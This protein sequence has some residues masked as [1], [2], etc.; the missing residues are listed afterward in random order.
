MES[1]K[2]QMDNVKFE[3]ESGNVEMESDKLE[4]LS[5][6]VQVDRV[7]L[8]KES[9]KLEVDSVKL[10]VESDKFDMLC[11]TVQMGSVKLEQESGNVEME[12]D[13][14]DMSCAK[15]QMDTSK[16]EVDHKASFSD[17]ETYDEGCWFQDGVDL[18]GHSQLEDDDLNEQVT[19]MFTSFI[20]AYED[21]FKSSKR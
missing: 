17:L 5:G 4:M 21:V 15:V 20:P 11:S 14:L 1:N 18:R 19:D 6:K 16:E 7:K 9:A 3:K 2:L 10:E 8:K 12:S 13:K